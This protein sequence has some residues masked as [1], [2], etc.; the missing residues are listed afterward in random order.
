MV[1]VTG[2]TH[3]NFERFKEKP[4]RKLK[5]GDTLIVC[6]DFGFLW[7]ESHQEKNSLKK[8]SE[9]RYNVAFVDGCHE[10]FNLLYSKPIQDWNGGKVH[11]I[12]KN[13]FHLMRGQ[14]YTI[15]GLKFFTFGGGHSDDI[16]IRKDANSWYPQEEPT[17]EEVLQGADSLVA[18][19]YNVDYII[20]HEPPFS[21]KKCLNVEVS[22]HLEFDDFFEQVKEN[23]NFEHWFFGKY[24]MNKFIPP[25]FSALF[26]EVVPLD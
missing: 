3:G 16:E 19:D 4:L 25:R 24:H 7:N 22:H 11:A 6:G 10:N 8:L 17:P 18:I 14:V 5:K 26:D 23:C 21:I 13:I 12:A 20:T 15:D 9:L 2:D 1:Y